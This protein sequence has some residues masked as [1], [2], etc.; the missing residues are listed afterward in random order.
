M[1]SYA[2]AIFVLN[3]ENYIINNEKV[4]FNSGVKGNTFV[5]DTTGLGGK[6]ADDVSA[7][8]TF[9]ASSGTN[10]AYIYFDYV[11]ETEGVYDYMVF[12]YNVYVKWC[13]N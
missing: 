7:K 3:D 10:A 12:D 6:S 5:W 1:Y 2:G 9:D 8:M 13:K 4:S 11:R